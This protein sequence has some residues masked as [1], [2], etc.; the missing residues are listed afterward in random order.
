MLEDTFQPVL[1]KNQKKKLRKKAKKQ[2]HKQPP[3]TANFD[4]KTKTTPNT[5]RIHMALRVYSSILTS[6]DSLAEIS[7]L[8]EKKVEDMVSHRISR[9]NQ[10]LV[11]SG[12]PHQDIQQTTFK[13]VPDD[14]QS[15]QNLPVNPN[16]M[17]IFPDAD[18][19]IPPLSLSTPNAKPNKSK[20]AALKSIEKIYVNQIIPN[21]KMNNVRN[22]FV[23][24]VPADWSHA[25]IIA[26]LKAWGDVIS[27]TTKHQHKYQTLHIKICLSTFSL[28]SFD[29]GIWQYSLG[30]QAV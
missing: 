11:N 10:N 16:N 20:K 18:T 28:A 7:F 25:K 24:D 15:L 26:K 12:I 30:D 19:I 1:T 17:Q 6:Q 2:Q 22:I 21:D 27:M 8:L 29:Q 9:A 5:G 14:Q 23:Y 4:I 13:S 3:H